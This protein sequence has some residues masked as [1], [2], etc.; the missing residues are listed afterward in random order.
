MMLAVEQLLW[1]VPRALS[2]AEQKVAARATKGKKLYVFLRECQ[3]ELLDEGFQRELIEMYRQS[4]AGKP[5]LAPGLL[6]MATLLQAYTGVSDQEAVELTVDS[7][8]WQLV[9]RRLGSEEPA[10]AQS[11]LYDFRMR[12]LD[13]D[14]E[15]DPN[16]GRRLK[17][18]VAK[19]RRT[20]IADP[21]MRHGR[22]SASRRINGYKR[23]ILRDL[24]EQLIL[25]AEVRPANEPEHRAL[26]ALLIASEAQDRQLTEL[27]I[28]RGYL[29]SE[30]IGFLDAHGVCIIGKPWPA[31][32]PA[33]HFS[34]REFQIN[35]T[36]L[37]ATCPAGVSVPIRPG[38]VSQFPPEH[39]QPCALRAR[40]TDS[41]HACSLSIHAQ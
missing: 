41:P 37:Q 33:G 2:A 35:L 17:D 18:G 7:R 14:L 9:L 39:C 6:A 12:L 3:A 21:E 26:E 19:D 1:T 15:P 36:R 38:A 16:G 40:C 13:Q 20:S 23:H 4:G 27:H 10:F 28:D 11:T 5:P 29:G 31:R 25:A 8:R 24:N 22:T 32:A 34:K 30:W